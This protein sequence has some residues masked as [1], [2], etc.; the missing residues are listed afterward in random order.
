MTSPIRFQFH[1]RTLLLLVTA[2]SVIL[3]MTK[4]LHELGIAISLLSMG[5]V[6][7]CV[8]VWSKRKICMIGGCA[9]ICGL[10]ISAPWLLTAVC[11]VGHK[12][13]P[14][15]V[16]VEDRSGTPISNATVRLTDSDQISSST[17]STDSSGLAHVVGDFQIYGTDTLLSK[18]GSVEV[19]GERLSVRAGGFKDLDRELDEM[20]GNWDLYAPTPPEVLV[21]LEPDGQAPADK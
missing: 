16:R 12:K 5:V 6:L 17:A 4:W 13:I 21:Q 14:V 3:S 11:W 1:L 20:V 8:G 15:T 9:L 7:L 10:V 18:T 2:V 19:L